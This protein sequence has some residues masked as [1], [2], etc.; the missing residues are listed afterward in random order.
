VNT[1]RLPF[2]SSCVGWP[3]E[4]V[5]T[6]GGLCD[7]IQQATSITR[8]T[9]LRHVYRSDREATERGLGYALHGRD[10]TMKRDWHVSYHRSKLHGRRVYYFKHSAIEYV[11]A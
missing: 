1:Q 8:R 7:M 9:F 11:F 10:L 6:E 4:D 2:F 3:R 5:D